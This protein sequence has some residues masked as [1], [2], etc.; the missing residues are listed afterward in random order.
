M[1]PIFKR[2]EKPHNYKQLAE[3]ENEICIVKIGFWTGTCTMVG[4]YID[5][6]F[7]VHPEYF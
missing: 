1:N 7:I 3:N 4:K 2:N 5:Y 6:N